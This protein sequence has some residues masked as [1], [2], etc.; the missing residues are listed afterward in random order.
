MTAQEA[1]ISQWEHRSVRVHRRKVFTLG[2]NS[3]GKRLASGSVDQTVRITRVD[4]NCAHKSEAELRG[5][6]EGVTNLAWHPAHPDK[7]ASIAGSEKSVR[8]W[9]TRASKNT[10]TVSTPGPNL[11]LA[12]SPDSHFLAVA[13]KEDVVSLV[14]TRRMKV[15]HKYPHKYQVNDL[16]FTRDGKMLLQCTGQGE[17]E[18]L[19]FPDMRKLRGLKGHTASVLS[20]ALDR[21]QRWV[22]TGGQD[23]V[24]CL[25]DTQD[26]ICQRT[27]IGM[28]HPIRSLSFSHD[29]R[30]L[31]IA[32]E[33]QV[34]DVENVETGQSLGRLT[35]NATPEDAAWNPRHHMIAFAGGYG[36][37][38]RGATF[39]DVEFRWRRG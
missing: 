11:Y 15:V 28:D 3:E 26:W 7:L 36:T 24:A 34:L 1:P 39:G 29:S 20:V 25:W 22:A 31:A 13:N 19:G 33:Q 16:V 4:A 2:W 35:L 14:D 27:Y 17:V 18:M 30:Y 12:W 38:D 5:H 21:Q 9:D 23:A 32:G 6:S 10:A 37:D 8:F